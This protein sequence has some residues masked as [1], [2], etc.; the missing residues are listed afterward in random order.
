MS[1]VTIVLQEA[2]YGNEKVWNA[3]KLS[4]GLISAGSTVRIFL[5]ADSVA[6]AKKSQSPPKG[7]YNIGEILSGLIEEGVEVRSSITCSKAR[8]I[9]EKDFIEG[10][11]VGHTLDLERWVEEG[12]PVMVF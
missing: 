5:Y 11:E 6:A 1:I 12:G 7:F 8:G 3:L 2:P 4:R 10:T 9:A